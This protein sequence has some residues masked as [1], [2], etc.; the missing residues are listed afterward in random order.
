MSKLF[1]KAVNI[2]AYTPAM[3]RK[4]LLKGQW[5]FAG[6]RST[7]GRF[8]GVSKAGTI[9]VSWTRKTEHVSILMQHAR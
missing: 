3:A 6:D 9:L 5:V 1:T 2:Q 4:Q 8:C 7:M